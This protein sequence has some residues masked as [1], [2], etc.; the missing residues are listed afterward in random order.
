MMKIKKVSSALH[1][2]EAGALHYGFT[3]KTRTAYP[4][5]ALTHFPLR[6]RCNAVLSWEVQQ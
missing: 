6:S 4:C 2:R 1:L 5:G 3:L